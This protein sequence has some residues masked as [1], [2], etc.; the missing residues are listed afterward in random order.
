MKTLAEQI[1]EVIDTLDE[2]N[3]VPHY[4]G[5][6][7]NAD[8]ADDSGEHIPDKRGKSHVVPGTPEGLLAQYLNNEIVGILKA[9]EK[10]KIGDDI[11]Q[12]IIAKIAELGALV[13]KKLQ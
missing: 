3:V 5:F 11:K 2:Y 10:S 4:Q 13:Q 1:R 9:V 6:S 7:D 12:E 8:D